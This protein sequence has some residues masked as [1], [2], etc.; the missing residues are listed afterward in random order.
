MLTCIL[1]NRH[2]FSKNNNGC[3]DDKA[4]NDTGLKVIPSTVHGADNVAGHLRQ[5]KCP[6]KSDHKSHVSHLVLLI[7]F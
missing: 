2:N 4:H 3:G 6:E 1:F 7:Q 5:K